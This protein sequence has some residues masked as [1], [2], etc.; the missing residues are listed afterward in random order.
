MDYVL[1]QTIFA[2]VSRLFTITLDARRY[3][4]RRPK[5]RGREEGVADGGVVGGDDAFGPDRMVDGAI[6]PVV[7]GIPV[8]RENLQPIPLQRDRY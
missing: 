8:E 6:E 3:M 4:L 1:C 2:D 7:P 5:T